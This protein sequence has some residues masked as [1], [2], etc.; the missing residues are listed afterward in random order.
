[1]HIHHYLIVQHVFDLDFVA[2]VVM[3]LLEHFVDHQN[4]CLVVEVGMHYY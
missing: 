2:V 4:I 3:E 1:M